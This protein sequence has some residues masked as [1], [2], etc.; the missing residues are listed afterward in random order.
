M[1]ISISVFHPIAALVKHL[2]TPGHP[3]HLYS[4]NSPVP[5]KTSSFTPNLL[6]F[7]LLTILEVAVVII[8][9]YVFIL[10][11]SLYLQENI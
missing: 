11:L 1:L 5:H 3:T 7:F 10:L 2:L 8:Q 9:A 4:H 6:V